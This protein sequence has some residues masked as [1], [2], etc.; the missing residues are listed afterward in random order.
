LAKLSGKIN[1]KLPLPPGPMLF[2]QFLQGFAVLI[3]TGIMAMFI[4][5]KPWGY[6]GMPI[7]NAFRSSFW[8]GAL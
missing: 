5:R 7:R 4:D 6:F 8:I 3:A 2:R 1:P